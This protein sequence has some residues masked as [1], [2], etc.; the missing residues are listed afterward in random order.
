MTR[1]EGRLAHVARGLDARERVLLLHHALIEDRARDPQ[2]RA[3]TPPE[4][5]AEFNHYVA[6]TNGVLHTLVAFA[7]SLQAQVETHRMRLGVLLT[8][9]G[10]SLERPKRGKKASVGPSPPD[11]LFPATEPPRL[12]AGEKPSADDVTRAFAFGQ[13]LG[14]A[15]TWAELRA[16]E[17]V[18]DEVRAEF[19]GEEVAPDVLI[20][21]LGDARSELL[22][23]HETSQPFTG[24]FELP[25]PSEA[26]AECL[27]VAVRR[28]EHLFS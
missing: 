28:N 15:A 27:R 8:I 1:S 17:V 3:T 7:L 11:V 12:A 23:L 6:L 26:V 18:L 5:Y 4:Q 20:E 2:I 14:I 22:Q 19:G 16:T 21:M 10:W 25:G 24:P 13:R 9:A